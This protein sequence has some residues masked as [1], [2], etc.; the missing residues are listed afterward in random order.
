MNSS[1]TLADS[2][3][4]TSLP[5][6][7][8]PPA[9]KLALVALVVGASVL[10]AHAFGSVWAGVLS[11]GFLLLS[12]RHYFLPSLYELTPHG[13]TTRHVGLSRSYPWSRFR[14]VALRREGVFLSTFSRPRRLDAWRGCYLRCPRDRDAVYRYARAHVSLGSDST[15]CRPRAGDAAVAPTDAGG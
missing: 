14:R 10:A 5:W 11:L 9:R 8:D 12:L 7:E 1:Q 6:K 15:S 4:W 2:F 13:I 3:T